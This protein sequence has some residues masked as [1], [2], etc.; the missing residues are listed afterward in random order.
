MS[1]VT[2]PAP[3]RQRRQRAPRTFSI[4]FRIDGVNYFVIPLRDTDPEVAVR[5]YRMKKR[6]EKGVILA[7]YDVRQDPAG[8]VSC[9]CLGFLK[10]DHCKHV[11]TLAAAGMIELPKPE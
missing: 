6:D 7:S 1:T 2:A 3:R 11:E 4:T 8:H 5:A 10:H 9:E